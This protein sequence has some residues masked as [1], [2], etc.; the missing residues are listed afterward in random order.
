LLACNLSLSLWSTHFP[1]LLFLPSS[2]SSTPLVFFHPHTCA[3]DPKEKEEEEKKQKKKKK[4]V[5]KEK[6]T[7]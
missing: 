1:F 2:H 4:V 3:A 7:K 6:K 5:L